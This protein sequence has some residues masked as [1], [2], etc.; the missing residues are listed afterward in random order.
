[1]NKPKEPRTFAMLTN[2]Q[3]ERK[4]SFEHTEIHTSTHIHMQ[5]Q[6][7]N[8]HTHTQLNFQF[9]APASSSICNP[10]FRSLLLQVFCRCLLRLTFLASIVCTNIMDF[11]VLSLPLPVLLLLL[12]LLL[13]CITLCWLGQR[14]KHNHESDDYVDALAANPTTASVCCPCCCQ[15]VVPVV[16]VVAVDVVVR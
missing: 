1:M 16:V 6:M 4:N 15:F 13:L 14:D 3:Q 8:A 11:H 5:M 10:F 2:S 12:S 9:F 7:R